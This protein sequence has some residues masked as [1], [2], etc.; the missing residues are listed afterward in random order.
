MPELPGVERKER[1]V[2]YRLYFLHTSGSSSCL[3]H[4]MEE[5]EDQG[6]FEG[7][8][9]MKGKKNPPNENKLHTRAIKSQDSCGKGER[10]PHHHRG[11]GTRL[12]MFRSVNLILYVIPSDKGMLTQEG[13]KI[14]SEK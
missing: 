1:I 14:F 12:L 7:I 9:S 10:H 13:S 3:G 8:C 6:T 2:I 5:A 11:K 4:A